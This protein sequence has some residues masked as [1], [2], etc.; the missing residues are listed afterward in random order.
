VFQTFGLGLEYRCLKS[1][2]GSWTQLVVRGRG[3]VWTDSCRAAPPLAVRSGF[4][5]VS[6]WTCYFGA[7][8]EVVVK[9]S[10][11]RGNPLFTEGARL[12]VPLAPAGTLGVPGCLLGG[13]HAKGPQD[14]TAGILA[15]LSRVWYP[16]RR[17]IAL[18]V[19]FLKKTL[20][21]GGLRDSRVGGEIEFFGRPRGFRGR[22][23]SGAWRLRASPQGTDGFPTGPGSG[24]PQGTI[25]PSLRKGGPP[26]P[27]LTFRRDPL[28]RR[29]S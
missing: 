5:G 12:S 7:P 18:S 13:G 8:T 1:H 15:L 17:A 19:V 24:G 10:R 11:S 28:A 23:T 22:G 16:A 3:G 20:S 4:S 29:S 14:A 9:P 21:Q 25:G 2:L 26:T 27:S 6:V